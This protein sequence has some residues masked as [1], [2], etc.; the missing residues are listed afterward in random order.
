MNT[1]TQINRHYYSHDGAH[2]EC[3][4]QIF[5][6]GDFAG[7]VER[8]GDDWMAY[9]NGNP[10]PHAH[11]TWEEAIETIKEVYVKELADN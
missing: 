2:M 10:T 5:I 8:E 9:T 11:P 4:D 3:E 7:I 1:E 6:N